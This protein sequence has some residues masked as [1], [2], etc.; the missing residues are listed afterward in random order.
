MTANLPATD[1]VLFLL[2]GGGSALFEKPLVPAADIAEHHP[3]VACL[4]RRYRGNEY[5]SQ[6]SFRRKGGRFA[7]HCAPAQVQTIV[8]SDI[9]GDPPDMIASGPTVPDIVHL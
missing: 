9:L 3:P 5:D 4:R 7:A 2:S 6:A 8:L 1:T